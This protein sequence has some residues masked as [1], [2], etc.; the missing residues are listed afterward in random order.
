M[1]IALLPVVALPVPAQ[2][3][4]AIGVVLLRTVTTN[5]NG[6]GVRVAQPEGNDGTNQP[7][8]FQVNP[9]N[10]GVTQP[11]GLFTYSSHLGPASVFPN[12]VGVESGHANAVAGFF[13][14]MAGGVATNVAH[15]HSLDADYFYDTFIKVSSPPN[16]N[17][18]VVNQSFIFGALSVPTQQ[19]VDSAYDNA[20]ALHDTLFV[21]GIGNGGPVYAPSTCYNGIGVGAYGGATSTGP[22]PDNGR[23]KPDITAPAEVTS[24]STPQVAG[25]AALLLQAGLRGDGGSD[26][27]NAADSRTL[28]ALLLNGAV[29]PANWTHGTASPLDARYG[30]GVLNVFNSYMQ[31]AGGKHP[32]IEQT[33]VTPG[34]LHPPGSATAEIASLRGWDYVTIPST[35][36]ADTIKHYYFNLT[37]ALVNGPFTATATLA[38]NRQ[39]G[40]SDINDLNLFLYDANTDALIAQSV[41]SVDNVEHLYIESLAPGRYD[42]QVLKRGGGTRGIPPRITD[43]EDY[44]LAWEFF[45]VNLGIAAV[46]DTT[47]V[48]TWPIYPAGF[49]PQ[50]SADP[51]SQGTWSDVSATATVSN[52]VN[53]LEV[54]LSGG[55]RFFRL[56]R[57]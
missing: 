6:G 23:C 46:S 13:F 16:P 26:T 42:L 48:L 28:K 50:S 38:W 19:A 54:T 31:L 12:S 18:R 9:G 24:F 22:T 29:K 37:N 15:V 4:D 41:S 33:S 21:S 47:A 39:N 1:Q 14:G 3:L 10:P 45:N 44:A 34:G 53:R 11:P 32:A 55:S 25:A 49:R 56:I 40:Q 20:A 5:L 30:A 17:A 35:K 57:P 52:G 43:S 27:N 8:A 7:P 2:A 36:T 51:A